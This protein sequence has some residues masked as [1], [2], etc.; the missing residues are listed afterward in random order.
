MEDIWVFAVQNL[1]AAQD[2]YKSYADN[3]LIDK[4]YVVQ[5]LVLLRSKFLRPVFGVRKL[6]P[7]YFGP[8][9]VEKV[10]NSCAYTLTLP[11]YM[12]G[13]HNTFHVSL[14]EPYVPDG[15][16]RTP[17]CPARM[18][19]LGVE[20][21]WVVESIIDHR[22]IDKRSKL[23]KGPKDPITGISP[24]VSNHTKMLQYRVKWAEFGIESSTWVSSDALIDHV[25]SKDIYWQQKWKIQDILKEKAKRRQKVEPEFDQENWPWM[26][27]GGPVVDPHDKNAT[28]HQLDIDLLGSGFLPNCV[29]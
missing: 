17:P 14:L 3:N 18:G 10:V 24:V 13:I 21:E 19:G 28:R 25:E 27:T 1:R 4:Q 5:D 2:R 16:N 20:E 7:R 8:F 15:K 22:N 23:S 12:K 9:P 11:D 29:G 26:E 6:M